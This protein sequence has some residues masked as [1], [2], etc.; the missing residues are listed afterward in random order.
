[1]IAE[2]VGGVAARLKGLWEPWK[3]FGLVV[4]VFLLAVE[5]S[6]PGIDALGTSSTSGPQD[7]GQFQARMLGPG[8]VAP[9]VQVDAEVCRA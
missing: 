3:L 6:V 1:M 7:H 4:F 5:S 2:D 8:P 9:G